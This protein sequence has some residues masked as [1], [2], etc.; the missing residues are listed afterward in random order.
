MKSGHYVRLNEND[1]LDILAQ[2]FQTPPSALMALNPGKEF[3]VGE[4]VFI[5]K[6]IGIYGGLDQFLDQDTTIVDQGYLMSGDYVWPVP[7]RTKISSGY[8]P[9]GRNHHD[10]IDVP[11]RVGTHIVSIADGVV[12]YSGN[13]ISGYGNLSIIKH[14]G[15]LVSVY[16]HAK[17]NFTKK[18]QK[19]H[20]GQVIAQVGMTGRTTGPHLHFETRIGKR[21]VN[22]MIYLSTSRDQIL[23]QSR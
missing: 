9:R 1:N 8:G 12:I 20:K 10:G 15:G 21:V 4:W 16:A 23:A 5:P 3:R 2:E 6:E 14:P 11:A 17:K 19:V 13:R 18:G 22:P 7:G